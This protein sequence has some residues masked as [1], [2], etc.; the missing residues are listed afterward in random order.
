MLVFRVGFRVGCM[1]DSVKL[2][3]CGYMMHSNEY[4]VLYNF[5]MYMYM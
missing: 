5:A 1:V 4:C 2:T 3:S